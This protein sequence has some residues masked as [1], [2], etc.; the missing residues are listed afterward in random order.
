MFKKIGAVLLEEPSF[1]CRHPLS[2]S[3]ST[4]VVIPWGPGPGWMKRTSMS[5]MP[6]Q[7]KKE[8]NNAN[9]I[10]PNPSRK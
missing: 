6:N 10:E 9:A 5:D 1:R 8:K 2:E 7:C 4:S 3:L